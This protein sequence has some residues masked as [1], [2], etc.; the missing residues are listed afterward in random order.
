MR[1]G[2]RKSRSSIEAVGCQGRN[3]RGG[4]A[5]GTVMTRRGDTIHGD[6]MRIVRM[7]TIQKHVP[8]GAAILG[9]RATS[10]TSSPIFG[11]KKPP[12]D[13]LRQCPPVCKCHARCRELSA[14]KRM[15]R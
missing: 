15:K 10:S 6:R 8:G 2:G 14:G 11:N 4:R 12:A 3:P 13:K 9:S 1:R 7:P 5:E